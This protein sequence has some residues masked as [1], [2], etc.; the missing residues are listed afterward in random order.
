MPSNVTNDENSRSRALRRRRIRRTGQPEDLAT[1]PLPRKEPKLDQL[2]GGNPFADH[3]NVSDASS[4]KFVEKD[5][6]GVGLWMEELELKEAMAEKQPHPETSNSLVH[7]SDL[8]RSGKFEET[9]PVPNRF[10]P[11]LPNDEMRDLG[12]RFSDDTSNAGILEFP[13]KPISYTDMTAPV[14]TNPFGNPNESFRPLSPLYNDEYIDLP[15]VFLQPGGYTASVPQVSS[16]SAAV[17]PRG[18]EEL[19]KSIERAIL[20][21][22]AKEISPLNTSEMTPADRKVVRRIM[23]KHSQSRRQA[24]SK[25]KPKLAAAFRA[26]QREIKAGKASHSRPVVPPRPKK[27]FVTPYSQSGNLIWSVIR[28]C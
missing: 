17:S 21:S 16:S 4:K 14:F 25:Y 12:S 8:L 3:T 23:F 9:G 27:S 13:L 1:R 18:T 26:R 10:S 24:S 11:E 7:G 15:D 20:R 22:K 6:E 28:G 5:E 2:D 19:D